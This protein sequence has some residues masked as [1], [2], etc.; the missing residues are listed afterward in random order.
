MRISKARVTDFRNTARPASDPPGVGR[1][2]P[3]ERDGLPRPGAV[4]C[5]ARTGKRTKVEEHALW[6][7]DLSDAA[8]LG[9]FK[10]SER[11][12]LSDQQDRGGV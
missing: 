1:G 3:L 12:N 2:F 4:A 9:I 11:R 10:S 6:L 5:Q 7:F 8:I